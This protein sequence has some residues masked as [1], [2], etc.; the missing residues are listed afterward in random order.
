MYRDRKLEGADNDELSRLA[1]EIRSMGH[2]TV[3]QEMKRQREFHE[4]LTRLFD[5]VPES[6]AW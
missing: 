2:S 1:E 5:D 6:L 4:E 3:W